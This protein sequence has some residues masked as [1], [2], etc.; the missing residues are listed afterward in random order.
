MGS[1]TRSLAL[2]KSELS[3]QS[4][5]TAR[6]DTSSAARPAL[7]V[8]RRPP[9]ALAAT[10]RLPAASPLPRARLMTGRPAQP[11]GR[12]RVRAR[13]WQRRL[14]R[15]SAAPF[16]SH[17]AASA[18][19]ARRRVRP[20]RAPGARRGPSIPTRTTVWGE[21]RERF[22]EKPEPV[23]RESREDES[24]QNPREMQRK[25]EQ[26]GEDRNAA[27]SPLRGKETVRLPDG[28][29]CGARLS[30]PSLPVQERV[31]ADSTCALFSGNRRGGDI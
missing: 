8:G 16:R 27:A 21:T 23:P 3:P 10:S 22:R 28:L 20:L 18:Q 12:R 7:R 17:D 13:S 4:S 5:L 29:A 11:R 30:G 31:S 15:S 19:C 24:D 6:R 1:F 2:S 26:P 14:S 25:G 9:P